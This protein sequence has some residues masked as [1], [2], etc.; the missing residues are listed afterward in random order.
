MQLFL[1]ICDFI[2]N[3]WSLMISE[4]P[5]SNRNARSCNY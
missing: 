3:D 1:L 4:D 5:V 2:Y